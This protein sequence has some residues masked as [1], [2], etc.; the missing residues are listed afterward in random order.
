MTT[1]NTRHSTSRKTGPARS[2][3]LSPSG[4]TAANTFHSSKK[5]TVFNPKPSL[6]KAAM[7]VVIF[8]P[9]T[10]VYNIGLSVPDN[11]DYIIQL[12]VH[13]AIDK[14]YLILKHL[15]LA[16]QIDTDLHSLPTDNPNLIIQCLYIRSGCDYISYFKSFVLEIYTKLVFLIA[17][18]FYHLYD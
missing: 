15:K 17:M 6:G 5:Y 3:H 12:N 8:S 7:K 16:F 4:F 2:V 9:D 14:K 10:D 11:K 18:D 1:N 13:Y